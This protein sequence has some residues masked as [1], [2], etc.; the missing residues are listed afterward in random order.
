MPVSGKFATIGLRRSEMYYANK[1]IQ[2]YTF[3][4]A[5]FGADQ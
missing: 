1:E 5:G 4:S 2:S 3:S